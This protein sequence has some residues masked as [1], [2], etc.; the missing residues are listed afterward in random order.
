[1][2]YFLY[3]G[4]QDIGEDGPSLCSL[5]VRGAPLGVN[6]AL[7][8]VNAVRGDIRFIKYFE[9][10]G[11]SGFICSLSSFIIL[12]LEVVLVITQRTLTFSFTKQP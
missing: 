10:S 5:G 1:V 11:D 8:D 12:N 2:L 6:L 9:R 3:I 7:G 4:I